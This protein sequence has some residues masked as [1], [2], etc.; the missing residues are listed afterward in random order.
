M[1]PSL[2]LGE[3][4]LRAGSLFTAAVGTGTKGPRLG[5]VLLLFNKS[6]LP[7]E[8]SAAPSFEGLIYVDIKVLI[9]TPC[10]PILFK[11]RAK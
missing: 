11:R 6:T 7:Q 2:R 5:F 3:H 9:R 8:E 10:T 4:S 1:W